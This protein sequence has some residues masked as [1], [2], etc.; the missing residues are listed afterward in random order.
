MGSGVIRQICPVTRLARINDSY[1]ELWFESGEMARTVCA[2]Q[3]FEIMRPES[4]RLR[5]PISAYEVD[6]DEVGLMIKVV[7]AGTLDLSKLE[8]GDSIDVMG[9]LGNEFT[10]PKQSKI[11]LVSGGIGYPP[12]SMLRASLDEDSEVRWLHGGRCA[13]DA[14]PCDDIYTDDG[15]AGHE[16]FVTIG[17]EEELASGAYDWLFAC[18]PEPLL[19]RCAELA[20]QYEV[21]CELSLEAYMACGI[22]VCYGCAVAIRENDR[23]V[24]KTVCKD[25]PVFN[26]EVVVWK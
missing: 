3:F 17:V 8:R 19:K 9:P 14:F 22:G 7:G 26:A 15:S 10:L 25:G 24:Y 4:E 18:G 23:V 5:I 1:F 11:L 16:G 13:D 20:K 6:G 2:G 21:K 12:M